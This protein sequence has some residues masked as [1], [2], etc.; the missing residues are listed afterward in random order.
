M[1]GFLPRKLTTAVERTLVA[2]DPL[3][4]ADSVAASPAILGIVAGRLGEAIV[5]VSH[6]FVSQELRTIT[7]DVEKLG[8]IAGGRGK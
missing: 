8:S 1:T 6:D 4:D 2:P 5:G 7:A 3:R